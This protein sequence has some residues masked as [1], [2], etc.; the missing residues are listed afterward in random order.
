ME[1][2][3]RKFKYRHY[4]YLIAFPIL[5]AVVLFA[6]Y[7]FHPD[8]L[9]GMLAQMF[10]CALLLI[11][12]N[13]LYILHKKSFFRA[14]YKQ[15]GGKHRQT[16][17]ALEKSLEGF[18]ALTYQGRRQITFPVIINRYAFDEYNIDLH[19][20]MNRHLYDTVDRFANLRTIP[21]LFIYPVLIYACKVIFD[22][23]MLLY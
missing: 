17:Y 10:V 2:E 6:S 4:E 22:I 8:T 20:T 12:H 16:I 21:H 1:T 19:N 15:Y 14:L 5:V 13:V 18:L 3:I 11:V 9:M 7:L 23:L